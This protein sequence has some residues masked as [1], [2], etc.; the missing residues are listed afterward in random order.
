MTSPSEQQHFLATD[1]PLYRYKEMC[2]LIIHKHLEPNTLRIFFKQ[3]K[4][5]SFIIAHRDSTIG[6]ETRTLL[7]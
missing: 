2:A 7:G 5:D 1:K 6:A 4:P 3:L